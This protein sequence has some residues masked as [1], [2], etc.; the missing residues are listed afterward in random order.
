MN[1]ADSLLL[2]GA[3]ILAG[4]LGTI[5][6][7][8]SLVSYP[9]LLLV[10]L[11]PVTANVTNTVAL[12]ANTIG[13]LISTGPEL[14]G[15]FAALRPRMI[16]AVLGGAVGSGLLLLSPAGSF[17]HVV[18]WLIAGA[19]V[20]LLLRTRIT[21]FAQRSGR[22]MRTAG[23]GFLAV[24]FLISIYGGY[25]GAAAGVLLL[26]WLMISTKD[27][28]AFCSAEKNVLLGS[29]NLSAAIGFAISGKVHWLAAL[30][31]AIGGLIGSYLGPKL[32][33]R[34]PQ[35]PTRIAI[36]IAGLALAVELFIETLQP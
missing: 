31:M 20:V 22:R 36:G 24:I 7:L 34:I 23:A 10:G 18:P 27:S 9:A 35:N 11:A 12:C 6:G 30:L 15:R 26:A 32:L 14:R 19:S 1:V 8:A 29:A 5:A 3:G 25:F 28:L 21:D 4:L 17:E 13:A 16:L 2:I 33:R